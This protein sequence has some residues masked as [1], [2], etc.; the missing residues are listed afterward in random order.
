[1]EN[2]DV[3]VDCN[4]DGQGTIEGDGKDGVGCNCKAKPVVLQHKAEESCFSGLIQ[5]RVKLSEYLVNL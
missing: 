1:M 4:D 5:K 2:V 3:S